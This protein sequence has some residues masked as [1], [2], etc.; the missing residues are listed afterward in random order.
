MIQK[1]PLRTGLDWIY[2]I[3]FVIQSV[4]MYASVLTVVVTV[5]LREVFKISLVWGYEIACWFV[6]ILVFI[7]MPRNLRYKSNIG[8]SF[9]YD[10]SPKIVQTI[11]SVIHFAVEVTVLIMMSSGFKIWITRVGKATLPASRFTNTLYYGVV[12]IGVAFSLLEMFT[13][14]I[15]LFV[16]KDEKE[17]VR[18]KTIEEE[19]IEE[20]EKEAGIV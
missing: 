2:K 13:E 7:G 14:I 8:V 12:G 1:N 18:E 20:A 4:C 15:D 17:V 9:V 19:L 11:F 3:F 16:K 5:I 10:I 6:I